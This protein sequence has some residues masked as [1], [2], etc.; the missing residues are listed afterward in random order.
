MLFNIIQF[1]K[2]AFC[3]HE[4]APIDMQHRNENGVVVWPC[5]KCNH[6]FEAECGL[7][8]LT[9]GKCTGDWEARHK[10]K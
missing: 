9:N 3:S 8:I 5:C 10:T 2:T 1:L 4:F 7:D 6:I